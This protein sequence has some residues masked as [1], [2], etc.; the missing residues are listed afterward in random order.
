MKVDVPYL[1]PEMCA[2]RLRG[3]TVLPGQLC[4]GGRP[5]MNACKG[6]SGGP[7]VASTIRNDGTRESYQVGIVSVGFGP[8]L[9]SNPS[10]YTDVEDFML[11]ILDHIRD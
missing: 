2:Y 1:D 8:C 5:A 3:R 11:W 4:A 10:I 9:F 7:L 6:D